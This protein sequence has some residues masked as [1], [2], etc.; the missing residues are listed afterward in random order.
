[1]QIIDY[2][3]QLSNTVM[4]QAM[5]LLKDLPS[6]FN[7]YGY[8]EKNHFLRAAFPEGFYIDADY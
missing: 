8:K 7:Q 5:G 4:Y 1:M 3:D 2:Q 6:I